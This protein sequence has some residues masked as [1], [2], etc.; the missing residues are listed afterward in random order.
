MNGV[1]AVIR[2][3]VGEWRAPVV[4]GRHRLR[5]HPGW[6]CAMDELHATAAAVKLARTARHRRTV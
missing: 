1:L 4:P 3:W 6:E 5:E 2:R